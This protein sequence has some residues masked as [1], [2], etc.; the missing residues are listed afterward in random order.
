M[1][2]KYGDSIAG[3]FI[4]LMGIIF[5]FLS[6]QIEDKGLVMLGSDFMPKL[7][8]VFFII[9]GTI[10]SYTGFKAS[11]NI[12]IEKNLQ[13]KA[14]Y[15]AVGLTLGLFIMYVTLLDILGF[16]VVSIL[17]LI[18]QFLIL[19]RKEERNYM[20]FIIIAILT[21]I[22]INYIFVNFFNVMLPKGILG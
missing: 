2:K 3:L 21:P 1:I 14:D 20:L 18:C 13:F 7:I 9:L 11:K 4:G 15:L 10:L 8:S 6:M 5:L 16:I 17:Y 22:I 19:A 12:E